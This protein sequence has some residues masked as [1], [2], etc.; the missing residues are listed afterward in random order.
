[1]G[2]RIHLNLFFLIQG[3][4]NSQRSLFIQILKL[5]FPVL[6]VILFDE[7]MEK[8]MTAHHWDMVTITEILLC[9]LWQVISKN[10]AL[11]TAFMLLG[12]GFYS[13]S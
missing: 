5:C 12:S 6:S 2:G 10:A 8:A 4:K 1:M 11:S 3:K 9:L 13:Q 7:N